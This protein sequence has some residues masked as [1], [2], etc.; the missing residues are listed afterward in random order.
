M[1]AARICFIGAA[2]LT[3]CRSD[4]FDQKA[5]AGNWRVADV[6]CGSCDQVD[7]SEIG[8]VMRLTDHDIVDPLGSGECLNDAAYRSTSV[9]SS[10]GKTA[11]GKLD[12]R[13][14]AGKGGTLAVVVATCRSLDFLVLVILGNDELA[15][16][17]DGEISYRLVRSDQPAH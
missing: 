11:I 6:Y 8:L 15:Y 1:N 9:S 12:P 17:S 13:W 10:N 16:S 5:L 14:K 2:L 7:R 4:A 3:A